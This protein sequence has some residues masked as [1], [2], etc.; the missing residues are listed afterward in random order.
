MNGSREFLHY[1]ATSFYH[2][3]IKLKTNL[4][5]FFSKELFRALF[6]ELL[7]TQ[8]RIPAVSQTLW[9]VHHQTTQTQQSKNY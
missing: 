2:L 4:I 3:S 7:Q 5:F 8:S 6:E 9:A 1:A